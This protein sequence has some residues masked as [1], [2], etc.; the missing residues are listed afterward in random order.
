M[1][2]VVRGGQTMTVRSISRGDIIVKATPSEKFKSL[3]R[4]GGG[5]GGS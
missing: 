5:G 2:E 1:A 3:A 4:R